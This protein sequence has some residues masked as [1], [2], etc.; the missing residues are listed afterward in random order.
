MTW[1][2]RALPKSFKRQ[3]RPHGTRGRDHLR[4]R[5]AAAFQHRVQVGRDQVGQEQEQAA[6]FGVDGVAGSG[7]VGGRR[8]HQPR[9]DG[10]GRAV[11]RPTAAVVWQS[12]PPSRS[13]A[14]AAGLSDSPSRARARLISWTERFCFRS[15]TTWSR[16]RFCLPGGLPS[17]AGNGRTGD[18]GDC[19]T[20]GQGPENSLEYIR[21]GRPP[22]PRRD[23]QRRRLAGL[24]TDDESSWR[25]RGTG[26]RQ[27]V[28]LWNYHPCCHDVILTEKRL[29]M[30]R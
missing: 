30:G 20:D 22:E 14:T 1:L 23:P 4:S 21:S 9:R 13:Q 5:E 6:K 8:P 29:L 2:W 19:G 24:R 27:L 18:R 12:P 11:P 25:A 17:R 10:V 7:R 16:S 28:D 26:E 15:A 3:Q